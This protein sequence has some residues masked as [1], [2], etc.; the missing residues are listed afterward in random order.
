MTAPPFE[1]NEFVARWNVYRGALTLTPLGE[2]PEVYTV[3]PM[4]RGA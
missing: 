2:F 4:K 1:A 3:K